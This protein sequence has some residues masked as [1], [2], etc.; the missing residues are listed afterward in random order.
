MTTANS[1]IQSALRLI[2]V[3]A[4][5]ETM[6]AQDAANS[7]LAMNQMMHGWKARG[8][9]IG[10]YD[11]TLETEIALDEHFIED[12]IY[13]LAVRLASDYGVPRPQP[14]GIDHLQGLSTVY[15]TLNPM[16]ADPGLLRLPSQFSSRYRSR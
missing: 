13:L 5:D 3:V 8:I 12:L 6:D 15:V 4:K 16:V 14:D 7:L 2:G 11:Y 10:H 9:D 1:A